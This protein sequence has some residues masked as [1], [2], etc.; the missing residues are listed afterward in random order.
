MIALSTL[1][2]LTITLRARTSEDTDEQNLNA[3]GDGELLTPAAP[4]TSELTATLEKPSDSHNHEQTTQDLDHSEI[5]AQSENTPTEVSSSEDAYTNDALHNSQL[6]LDLTLDGL[7]EGM[8][9]S[10]STARST[11]PLFM[12]H[13]Q[14][15]LQRRVR[16]AMHANSWHRISKQNFSFRVRNTSLDVS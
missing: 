12:L 1:L 8:S 10:P 5:P 11:S 14:A 16:D 9:T 2:L 13:P 3:L 7:I 6:H 4:V 15:I